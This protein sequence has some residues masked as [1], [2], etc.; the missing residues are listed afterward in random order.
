MYKQIFKQF[1]SKGS[2]RDMSIFLVILLLFLSALHT[3]FFSYFMGLLILQVS[4]S[5]YSNSPVLTIYLDDNN[6][7]SLILSRLVKIFGNGSLVPF[8]YVYVGTGHG[9]ATVEAI[10]VNNLSLASEIFP[11]SDAVMVG[12]Y[13]EY[14]VY[15]DAGVARELNLRV[16][17]NVSVYIGSRIITLK[18]VGLLYNSFFSASGIAVIPLYNLT[19]EVSVLMSVIILKNNVTAIQQVREFLSSITYEGLPL[20]EWTRFYVFKNSFTYAH[21]PLEQTIQVLEIVEIIYTLISLLLIFRIRSK[22]SKVIALFIIN[23]VEV[24]RSFKLLLPPFLVIGT[25]PL[26]VYI[27]FYVLQDI[28]WYPLYVAYPFVIAL[29]GL[30]ISSVLIEYYTIISAYNDQHKFLKVNV[31]E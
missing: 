2:I 20:T 25:I 8:G 22:F 27:S 17:D 1:L 11:V 16:G 28:Y 7:S 23:G 15:L 12:K 24:N 14:G 10:A 31:I 21:V 19:E 13:P 9:G 18:V 30:V 4:S 29:I 5:R 26:L 3:L 6:I